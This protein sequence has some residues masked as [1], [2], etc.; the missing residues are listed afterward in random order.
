[1]NVRSQLRKIS[2]EQRLADSLPIHSPS[3]EDV[4]EGLSQALVTIREFVAPDQSSSSSDDEDSSE[5]TEF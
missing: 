1:M 2:Q 3:N 5:S 4:V